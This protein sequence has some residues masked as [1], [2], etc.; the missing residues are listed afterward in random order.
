MT[1][2]AKVTIC[3]PAYGYPE[4]AQRMISSTISENGRKFNFPRPEVGVALLAT[5]R[6]YDCRQQGIKQ[7]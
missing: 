5:K 6:T 3:L 7:D 4:N 1:N 2:D